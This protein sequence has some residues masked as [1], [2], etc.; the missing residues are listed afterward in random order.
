[1]TRERYCAD[2]L[3]EYGPY[4]PDMECVDHD[5]NH[6]KSFIGKTLKEAV[7]QARKAD[8]NGEACCC[9]REEWSDRFQDW[10]EVEDFDCFDL[11]PLPSYYED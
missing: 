7:A 2:A 1:M 5:Q 4:D 9:R 3:I 8:L 11:K 6:Y 10:D